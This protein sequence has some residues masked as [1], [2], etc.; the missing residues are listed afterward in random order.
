PA[1][2]TRRSPAATTAFRCRE[3]W[4]LVRLLRLAPDTRAARDARTVCTPIRPPTRWPPRP[5]PS[6]VT[7]ASSALRLGMGAAA[8]PRTVHLGR[9]GWSALGE[10]RPAGRHHRR[11]VAGLAGSGHLPQPRRDARQQRLRPG[12]RASPGQGTNPPRRPFAGGGDRVRPDR[13]P[14]RPP[15]RPEPVSGIRL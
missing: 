6:S 12:P 4:A 3:H 9:P 14:D 13:R 2:S 7:R 15:A 11:A 1:R 10:P 5:P 8:G